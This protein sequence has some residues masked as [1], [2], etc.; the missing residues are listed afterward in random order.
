MLNK[1]ISFSLRN[2][3]LIGVLAAVII[4]AGIFIITRMEVDV[5]PDLNAPTVTVM[6]E[7]PGMAAEE[8]EQQIT[9]PLETALN[10]V[11]GMRRIR[12]NSA[13]G[14]STIWIE[15]DWD[16]DTYRARQNVAERLSGVSLPTASGRPVMGP[17][18]SVL[19]EVMFVGLTSDS[20]SSTELRTV[21][22]SRIAPR[23]AAIRGVAQVS[24]IGGDEQEYQ[25]LLD[26]AAMRRYDVT[27]ADVTDALEGIN[28]NAPGGAIYDYG[29]EYLIRGTLSTKSVEDIGKAVIKKPEGV[30]AILL[31]NIAEVKT[32][33][34]F[35]VTGTASVSSKP[36]VLLTV[37][38]QPDTGTITLTEAI[39]RTIDDMKTS[40]P[41][42]IVLHTDLYRQQNFIDASIGNIKESL[43]E[44]AVFVC[45]IL[46]IFLM[47]PRTTL[48]SIVTIPISLIM[49]L[50]ILHLMKISV[51]TMSIGGIAIAIGSLVDDAIVDVE[52]VFKRLRQN[53]MLPPE[54]RRSK[55][56]VVFDASREVRMPILNSTLIIIV[57][58]VPLFFLSGMEGRMLIPLGVAFILAL[59]SSTLVALT[60]T[61]VL[62]SWLLPQEGI[63]ETEPGVVR[64]M[65]KYYSR[66]LE[67]ALEHGKS[68]LIA[69]AV[70][71][72][73]A[74]GWF[75]TFGS[76]FLPPFNEGSFTINVSAFP[77]ISIEESDK[78]GR[79]AE[80]ILLS[81]KEIDHVAR[82]TGRAELDE[83]A[84][85]LNVSEIEAPFHLTD[86]S[87]DEVLAELR[88][89]L[90]VIQGANIEIGQPIS[91]R[92]D[93]MLSGTEA[94][95]AIKVFGPD[96]SHIH[97]IAKQIKEALTGIE[98][99]E[100]INVAQQS[101]RPQ[102]R[103]TPRR[104]ILAHY[105]MTVPDF[106]KLVSS[107]SEGLKVSQVYEGNMVYDIV[108]KMNPSYTRSINTLKELPV[109]LP[110][111]VQVPLETLAEIRVADGPDEVGRENLE[112]L[113][114]VGVNVQGA[115]LGGAVENIKKAIAE[116]VSL[117]DGYRVEYGG[118]FESEQEASRTLMIT[119]LL[120]LIV[121]FML[122]YNQFRSAR[123]SLIVMINLP[124]ALI[125]GVVAIGL[126]S[127]VVS[128]PA[129]IG[130]I[131]LF[132][133]ATRNGMLLVDRYNMLTLR[134]MSV[135]EAVRLGSADRLNPII[136]TALTSA[137]A[138]IPLA[139]GD[140]TPGN[141]IQSPM[142]KVIL[143]GLISSTLLN[144]YVVPV[145]Y[146]MTN[147]ARSANNKTHGRKYSQNGH[148]V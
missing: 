110:D 107:L 4:T 2:R 35:P 119:S 120:S 1:I 21:A 25:I 87:K 84:L 6:T 23:L 106:G 147:H 5:F 28:D 80:E 135:T 126:G 48:I 138:L 65:K 74:L 30:P 29:N 128:I 112:R 75:L 62:C 15:F 93:A 7:A 123:Q 143:G 59:L 33:A 98:G 140:A 20:L 40:L 90:K 13:N 45:I 108:L 8:V 121:I 113:S 91:H 148:Y 81:V 11:A 31:E 3:T 18:T 41:E 139:A 88:E 77:G 42:S 145:V 129:I 95:V 104:E 127:Q 50:I 86:R 70:V 102:L 53:S 68:I 136:M 99:L 122:L 117:P 114:V 92:I 47:N 52:N 10:G 54:E 16:T 137:L 82:K 79:Q 17:P 100:D 63:K 132:G 46:F 73:A 85:G 69:S 89:K 97:T 134:G 78:I 131:S 64:F 37:T 57:S 125:G 9:F 72:I 19:G 66:S 141:E 116:K 55:M 43:I 38:K 34:R 142:A 51:N 115:D 71:L 105:G 60:L 27:L 67:W 61:P 24:V 94:N 124:L 103:I 144:I 26:P 49:T 111:G 133:I 118:Q 58:F 109:T 146:L 36:G 130:F 83:H 14:F 39:D 56:E 96:L 22:D 32:G 12:S 76:S 44:G 101:T